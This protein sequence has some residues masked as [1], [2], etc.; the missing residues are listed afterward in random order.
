MFIHNSF[1]YRTGT[2]IYEDGYSAESGMA[3]VDST[4]TGNIKFALVDKYNRIRKSND[5]AFRRVKL[6]TVHI[7]KHEIDRLDD[8]GIEI[9]S[10][11]TRIDFGGDE[12]R[13]ENVETFG[14]EYN[15][16]F[17]PLHL[18][19]VTFRRLTPDNA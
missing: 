12:W 16:N 2:V 5:V 4:I 18:Y 14:Q 11:N 13:A 1:L 8:S 9:E 19:E 3:V 10:H 17:F 7:D 6:M 15:N